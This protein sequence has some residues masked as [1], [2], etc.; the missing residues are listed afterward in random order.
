M[1][2]IVNNLKGTQKLAKRFLKTLRGEDIVLFYG[3]LGSGKTTFVQAVAKFLG[4]K[5]EITS[6]TFNIIKQY[7]GKK[8]N[9][10]HVDLY[11]ID[12]ERDLE[13]LGI[14]ELLNDEKGIVMV[15]WAENAPSYFQKGK[16]VFIEKLGGDA[17]KFVI[18][19]V[20]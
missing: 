1:E 3:D 14:Q 6:P 11:R 4:I 9:L 7:T 15:E 16:K 12:D 17:R 10:Y 19:D 5:G 13:M 2:I 8:F 20:K 18:E